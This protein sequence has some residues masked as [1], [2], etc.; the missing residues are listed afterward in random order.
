MNESFPEEADAAW[1]KGISSQCSR[2]ILKGPSVQPR[3]CVGD[4]SVCA[5]CALVAVPEGVAQYEPRLTAFECEMA[6]VAERGLG[7]DALGGSRATEVSVLAQEGAFRDAVRRQGS[8][9]QS[10]SL[11]ATV[12]GGLATRRRHENPEALAFARNLLPM[13]DLREKAIAIGRKQ[14]APDLG[15]AAAYAAGFAWA[16]ALNDDDL[17]RETGGD[18]PSDDVARALLDW[19]KGPS[20]SG[21]ANNQRNVSHAVH[22]SRN[23]S[24]LKDLKRTSNAEVSLRGSRCTSAKIVGARRRGI[25]GSTT[26]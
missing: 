5:I 24:G 6:R 8:T 12:E 13:R 3:Y 23:V 21:G 14:D 4:L 18:Y 26:P 1:S 22:R 2:V 10:E 11:Q 15:K 9:N 20:S 16:R 25:R 19:F 7:V 17:K